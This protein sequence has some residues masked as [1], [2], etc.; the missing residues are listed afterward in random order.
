M[1]M[2]G[3]ARGATRRAFLAHAARSGLAVPAL[4]AVLATACS[5]RPTPTE[6]EAGDLHDATT[7]SAAATTRPGATPRPGG[8]FVTL[9]HI[10][11]TSLS[12]DDA[13]PT[14]LY[15]LTANIHEGL[16]KLDAD[17]RLVPAL[18]ESYQVSPDGKTWVFTLRQGVRWHDGQP[19]TSADV[20]YNFDWVRNPAN[21][22]VGQ[23]VF[24]DVDTVAAPDD[25]TVVV[26][27]KRP[28]ASFAALT[29]TRLLVPKH[30]HE[31]I[32]EQAYK[33]QPVGTGPYKLKELKPAEYGLL[34]A[35]PDYW[36]GRP[37]IDFWR[38]DVV[39]ETSV[40]AIALQTGRADSTTWALAPEDTLKL[41]ADPHFRSYRAPGTAVNHF[42]LNT[43]RPPLNDK[44]VRQAMLY[45]IDR[46]SL[47][48]DL[49]RGLAEPASANLSPAIATYYE[50]AVAHYPRNV[51]RSK[52]LLQQAGWTPGSDGVRANDHGER[53]SLTCLVFVGD[54]LRR[55]EAEIVQ[56]Q[57]R[58]V[59]IALDLRTVD[60]AVAQNLVLTA[61]FD[62]FATN[63]TYGG[64][65][66][67]PDPDGTLRSDGAINLSHWQNPE[68]DRL[69]DAGVSAV[70]QDTRRATYSDLQKLV[71][72]EVP[73]LYIMYWDTVLLFN[74]RIKGMP[75]SAAN[76]E[77][78]YTETNK[79]WIEDA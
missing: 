18:A 24:K 16:L 67:D 63:W 3:P 10:S 66:G 74:Q 54:D 7:L 48:R 21:G 30:V 14:V 59:G 56:Q 51:E 19:F 70:D 20:A 5:P 69:I 41:L 43:T 6:G 33:Q 27:L 25:F 12:P 64:N 60:A 28:N 36:Q 32:G 8:T 47:V 73:F 29:A 55:S 2:P 34:E 49:M 37:W 76:P 68:A 31:R 71:A 11:I 4:G 79:Y 44:R 75:P 35:N 9:S 39:P 45:A 15:V 65:A 1:H 26:G 23:T 57:L 42:A 52:A 40:R 78:L 13:S 58:D 22:A 46:E 17:Y 72:E 62:L 77:A 38:E 50:P 61:N 53:L